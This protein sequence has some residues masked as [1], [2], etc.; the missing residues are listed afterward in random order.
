VAVL[1][2]Q[3]ISEIENVIDS[4]IK[5]QPLLSQAR[6][7][8]LIN[9]LRYF[10]DY[11]RLYG[12]SATAAG[13]VGNFQAW[14]KNG[15]DGMHFAVRWI[16]EHCQS[17][18]QRPQLAY[19][20][21]AYL[22]AAQLHQEAMNYSVIWD[23]MS[24]LRH[25]RVT[26]EM[27]SDGTIRL[28]SANPL[29]DFEVAGQL[30]N[31]PDN[32]DRDMAI[33]LD[34][35]LDPSWLSSNLRTHTL[36]SGKLKYDTPNMVFERVADGYARSLSN[37]WE[38]DGAWDLG[39]YTIRQLR[40]FWIA[41][42]TLCS[43]HH[44]V[45]LN[46]RIE[47]GALDSVIRVLKRE[48]WEK[49][50]VR[51]SGLQ[52]GVVSNILDD[53]IYDVALYG[54][55]MKNPDVTYQPFFP[56]G[57]NLIAL[58]NWLVLLSNAERNI[59]DLVSIKRPLIHSY[60]RNRKEQHWIQELSP[61]LESYGLKACGPIN[62]T[63]NN[64]KS[65]LDILVLD[66]ESRFGLG[67]QLK[68]LI[69]P[70]RIRDVRYTDEELKKGINQAKLSLAWLN[71]KPSELRQATGLSA[72]ELESC[73]FKALVLSKNTM[74]SAWVYEPGIPVVSERLLH[75]ILGAPHKYSLQSLWRVG[76]EHRYL[77]KRDKHFVDQDVDVEFGGIHFLGEGLGMS[78]K[79]PWHPLEDIDLDGLR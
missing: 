17:G 15:Q 69:S 43:I 59:W 12:M 11:V 4:S 31:A 37:L 74:G 77:P 29:S 40:E 39:G 53:L 2:E 32:P 50:F 46:S 47:G 26:A 36:G 21:V 44:W 28:R 63:F 41:L 57:S 54:P 75:W 8:A 33:F 10:E 78:L 62:F 35:Y 71:S 1:N 30:I 64:R 7:V 60:L 52:S 55:G 38:F 73:E 66:T 6:E 76:D 34:E 48:I 27:E 13:S 67:C 49:E 22:Q 56:V 9:L 14:V 65:D 79:T 72:I 20:E 51:R 18:G 25:K 23:F 16:F 45:C 70:D 19:D 3:D 24:L 58:S 5:S 42:V 68:W 61:Q